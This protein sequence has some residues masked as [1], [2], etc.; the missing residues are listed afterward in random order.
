M[1][2][3]QESNDSDVQSPSDHDSSSRV[4]RKKS[5]SKKK[6]PS[7]DNSDHSPDHHSK[8]T[9]AQHQ[10][11]VSEPLLHHQGIA[12]GLLGDIRN[13][14]STHQPLMF[15]ADKLRRSSTDV[16]HG[17]GVD[18]PESRLSPSSPRQSNV[19]WENELK[20][21][22]SACQDLLEASNMKRLLGLFY[23]CFYGVFI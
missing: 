17:V 1:S 23:Y 10:R 8:S 6:S 14:R 22:K 11:R 2:N 4:K 12:A 3:K 15:D 5:K 16:T 21:L 9:D 13:I 7:N 20:S 18:D 19:T